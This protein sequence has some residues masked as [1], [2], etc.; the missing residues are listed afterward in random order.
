MVRRLL[1][2]AIAIVLGGS[3]AAPEVRAASG[4]PPGY[5]LVSATLNVWAPRGR[6]NGLEDMCPGEKGREAVQIVTMARYENAQHEYLIIPRATGRREAVKAVITDTS[7]ATVSP[8]SV[9]LNGSLAT[10]TFVVTAKQFGSTKITFS[11]DLNHQAQPFELPVSVAD[12]HYEISTVS[13]WHPNLGFL[14]TLMSAMINVP[15]R[16]GPPSITTG[17]MSNG[18]AA[19]AVGGCQVT[20]EVSRSDVTITVA[21]DIW[22]DQLHWSIAFGNMA[23]KTSVCK[24]YPGGDHADDAGLADP[25]RFDTDPTAMSTVVTKRHRI[26]A[27]PA[28]FTGT[29]TITV[30]RVKN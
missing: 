17:H 30:K 11:D 6:Q 25:L 14:P 7:V 12:C 4:V 28:V 22:T 1:A 3:A 20:Y 23:S 18:A 2:C 8:G 5:T 15:I 26:V 9:S 13:V 29:V 24:G 10:R 27:G 21:P 16:Q 19:P